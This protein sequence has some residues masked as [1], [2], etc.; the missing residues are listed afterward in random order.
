MTSWSITSWL[1]GGKETDALRI[2][3]LVEGDDRAVSVTIPLHHDIS[4][5]S[6]RIH[7]AAKQSLANVDAKDLTL[8]KVSNSL[9]LIHI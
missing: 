3:C 4:M 6:K 5:L 1:F 9:C 2:R 7:K 8:F